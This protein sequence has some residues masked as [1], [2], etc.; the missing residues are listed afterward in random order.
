M[1]NFRQ[2]YAALRKRELATPFQAV[3]AV[4]MS[5]NQSCEQTHFKQI[6][7]GVDCGWIPS[8][9]EICMEMSDTASP[10]LVFPLLPWRACF[11]VKD[12]AVKN[13]M[14]YSSGA[15]LCI[16]FCWDFFFFDKCM[17]HIL[18]IFL[19]EAYF[20]FGSLL[21]WMEFFFIIANLLSS[22]L[23][24]KWYLLGHSCHWFVEW[25]TCQDTFY[26]YFLRNV[27]LSDRHMGE[28]WAEIVSL[29][30]ISLFI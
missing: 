28:F 23:I 24:S 13:A 2:V 21:T 20:N 27:M 9:P 14:L 6:W 26:F 29:V 17:S 19:N 12:P 22:V 18:S 7:V 4:K 25:W 11:P 3:G 8:G 5:W 1:C 15:I 30:S 16:M 10:Y